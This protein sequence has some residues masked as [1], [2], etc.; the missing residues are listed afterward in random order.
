[1]KILVVSDTHG[2]WGRLYDVVAKQRS[3]EVVIHLGDGADDLENVRYNFPEKMMTAVS[4]NCDRMSSLEA[5]G[6]ITLEGKRI[7]YTHGHIYD[8]KYGYQRLEEAARRREA[9]ICLFGH[10][11][12][13]LCDYIDGLYIMNPG[14]L[15]HPYDGVPTYGLIEITKAGIMTNIVKADF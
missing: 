12:E 3:A 11:H 6:E 10:T 7:F 14:S 4:G 1:M 2:R 15:G 5:L 9:D 8:V 13:P